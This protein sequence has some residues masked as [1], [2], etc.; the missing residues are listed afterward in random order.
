MGSVF[1]ATALFFTNW[2]PLDPLYSE[3]GIE[4]FL[5]YVKLALSRWK[6]TGGV[7]ICLIMFSIADDNKF[8]RRVA[9]LK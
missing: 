7:D 5:S 6:I 2:Q 8:L 4:C 9:S 3:D 1:D